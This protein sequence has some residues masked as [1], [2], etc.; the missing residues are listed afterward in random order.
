MS[1]LPVFI[2]GNS[3]K[4]AFL[5]KWLGAELEHEELDL[6][7]PQSMDIK[8]IASI[9]AKQAYDQIR[10]PVL[11]EDASLGFE[12][13]GGLPGPFIKWFLERLS[14][15]EICDLLKSYDNKSAL[16]EVCYC[17]FDGTE[18][19]FFIGKQPGRIADH[20]SGK[21]GFG[22]DPIFTPF[23]A[24][25]T[26]ADMDD[27]QLAKHALRTSKIFPELKAYLLDPNHASP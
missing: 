26:Y 23:D 7:E 10:K 18:P 2:T 11:V 17:Y 14:L 3:G 24:T 22:F 12:S 4:A 13:L 25:V 27:E 9:K 20:P 21:G 19:R 16:H 6:V 5:S 15:Q 1:R 8:E